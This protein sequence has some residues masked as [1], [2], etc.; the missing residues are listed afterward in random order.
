MDSPF[1]GAL[2]DVAAV[3]TAAAAAVLSKGGGGAFVPSFLGIMITHRALPDRRFL[4]LR[5]HE[6]AAVPK[7]TY[8]QNGRREKAQKI[9]LV[10]SV[11]PHSAPYRALISNPPHF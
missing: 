9:I 4:L 1:D 3:E 2:D 10:P 8:E 11:D 7:Q 6:T 5:S